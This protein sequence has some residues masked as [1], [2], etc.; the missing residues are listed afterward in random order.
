MRSRSR[1][2]RRLIGCSR[3]RASR[4]TAPR[5]CGPVRAATPGRALHDHG[6]Q[7]AAV[8]LTADVPELGVKL[9]FGAGK[10]W[11]AEVGHVD[12]CPVPARRPRARSC[13]RVRAARGSPDSTGGRR[14]TRGSA[15]RRS[16]CHTAEATAELLA[17]LARRV[18]PA[19]TTDIRWWTG[20]THARRTRRSTRSTSP[21]WRLETATT[22]VRAGR[23]RA[24]VRSR[25][26]GGVAARARPTT[27]GWKERD[28][29]L[30]AHG[31]ALFDRNGNAGSDGLG[32]RS[33]GRRLEPTRR[34]A[35]IR[36]P[37]ARARRS[38]NGRARCRTA[39]GS[40]DGSATSASRL[41]SAIPLEQ[42]LAAS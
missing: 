6:A 40:P 16:R 20:W 35:T 1:E 14:S 41:G 11:A 3:T 7:A 39:S 33:R 24:P 19:T 13:A 12:P 25:A 30:G 10:R 27:M 2:R 17:P 8:E 5:G 4:P 26:V 37:A 29:Y 23:R 28:W 42:E 18:R 21:R 38:P 34:T 15:R 9:R 36:L 32:R 22:G 31:P